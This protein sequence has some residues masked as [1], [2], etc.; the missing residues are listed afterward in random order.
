MERLHRHLRPLVVAVATL[1]LSAGV[2][3]AGG[4][5]TMPDAASDGLERAAEAA[6]KTV[7]VVARPEAPAV[8]EQPAQER[9]EEPEPAE[10]PEQ[11][12]AEDA[13]EP[14]AVLPEGEEY[15]THGAKVCAAAQA[16][17]PEGYANR[18]EYVSKVARDNHG[19]EIAAEKA[20]NGGIPDAAKAA[21]EKAKA[22]AEAAGARANPGPPAGVGGRP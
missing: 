8:P 20:A 21:K 15:E 5:L 22:K 18:G 2:V 6:G 10:Q 17:L 16:P 12:P 4:G 13:D 7:P 9:P 3:L 14:C 19:A 11:E 1:A